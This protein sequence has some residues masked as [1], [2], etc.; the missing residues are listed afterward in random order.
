MGVVVVVPV[1]GSR[2]H[3]EKGDR[4]EEQRLAP[5][6]RPSLGEFGRDR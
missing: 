6:F 2:E 3:G 1:A 4:E 5:H